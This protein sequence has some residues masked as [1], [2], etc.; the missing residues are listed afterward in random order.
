MVLGTKYCTRYREVEKK[1]GEILG[2]KC[3]RR[4]VSRYRRALNGNSEIE[5][6][7]A[8][9][10]TGFGV[11]FTRNMPLTVKGARVFFLDFYFPDFNLIIELDGP[12]HK[13]WA[14]K[15]RDSLIKNSMRNCEILRI[16]NRRIKKDIDGVMNELSHRFIDPEFIPEEIRQQDAHLRRIALYG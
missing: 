3:G 16:K 13:A 12:E 15:E 7:F 1:R 8:E 4:W 6:R 10:V 9:K 5:K 2:L 11:K 14:D